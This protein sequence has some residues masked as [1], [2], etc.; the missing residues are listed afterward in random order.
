MQIVYNTYTILDNHF[1]C[2]SGLLSYQNIYKA[3][4]ICFKIKIKHKMCELRDV[5]IWQI[6]HLITCQTMLPD[7]YMYKLEP[8][9]VFR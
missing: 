4:K 9:S 2:F 6:K 3:N 8:H 7:T 1:P 5:I